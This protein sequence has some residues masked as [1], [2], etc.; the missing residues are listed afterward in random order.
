MPHVLGQT[1][2]FNVMDDGKRYDTT[3]CEVAVPIPTPLWCLG[4]TSGVFIDTNLFFYTKSV[5][6]SSVFYPVSAPYQRTDGS[7]AERPSSDTPPLTALN[8]RT[9]DVSRRLSLCTSASCV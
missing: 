2:T 5:S 3:Y 4:T 8:S 1:H 7:V 6:I 9:S